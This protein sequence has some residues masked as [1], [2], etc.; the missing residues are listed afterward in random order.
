MAGFIMKSNF[1]LCAPGRF[2]YG[3]FE[4]FECENF[5]PIFKEKEV[6]LP[7]PITLLGF[8][9]F[10][11]IPAVFYTMIYGGFCSIV[12]PFMGFLGSGFKRAIDIKDFGVSLPGHGG[13]IDRMD[14]ISIVCLFNYFFLIDVVMRDN[15]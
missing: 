7:Y 1:W 2:D 15:F 8:E 5:N 4:D 6:S 3:L 10:K 9:T 13:F 14:C 11:F 12:A